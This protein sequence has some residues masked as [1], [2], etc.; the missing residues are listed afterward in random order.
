MK[1]EW[2][3]AQGGKTSVKIH[4]AP[5]GNTQFSI[6]WSGDNNNAG[7]GQS[8][9]RN[10]QDQVNQYQSSYQKNAYDGYYGNVPSENIGFAGAPTRT[11]DNK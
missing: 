8:S 9:Q 4:N 6:G 1:H 2:D 7:Y 10:Y 11:I 5:G 3:Y